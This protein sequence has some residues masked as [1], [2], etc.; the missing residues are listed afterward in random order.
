MDYVSNPESRRYK[1]KWFFKLHDSSGENTINIT[2]VY[3]LQTKSSR[4]KGTVPMK[5]FNSGI[6]LPMIEFIMKDIQIFAEKKVKRMV[7][8]RP[9]VRY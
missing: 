7:K 6:V 1:S 9:M 4:G 2:C 8:E 5:L 3:I